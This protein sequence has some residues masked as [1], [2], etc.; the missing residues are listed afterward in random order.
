ME[1]ET[2][3][4]LAGILLTRNGFLS[5]PSIPKRDIEVKVHSLL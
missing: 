5:I 2:D 4:T 3:L 1:I